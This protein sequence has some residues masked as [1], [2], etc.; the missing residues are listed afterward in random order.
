MCY[1][2][3][4]CAAATK[5]Y[6]LTSKVCMQ[7]SALLEFSLSLSCVFPSSSDPFSDCMVTAAF[8]CFIME[9]MYL[10]LTFGTQEGDIHTPFAFFVLSE[11]GISM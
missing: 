6:S 5:K 8:V 10:S 4:Y 1:K 7:Q 9:V 2:G 3:V 11:N